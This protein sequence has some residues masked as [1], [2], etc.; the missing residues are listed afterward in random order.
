MKQKAY[1]SIS[2][3]VI[4]SVIILGPKRRFLFVKCFGNLAADRFHVE[5]QNA[6]FAKLENILGTQL[7][8]VLQNVAVARRQATI[9]TV[10]VGLEKGHTFVAFVLG[11]GLSIAL[12]HHLGGIHSN[13][14]G[15]V[16]RGNDGALVLFHPGGLVFLVVLLAVE[17]VVDHFGNPICYYISIQRS[18]K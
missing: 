12:V 14:I 3:V 9:G 18:G 5:I 4:C 7:V 11:K 10:F 16:Q 15:T 1:N 17:F 8:K 13:T 6:L 2:S